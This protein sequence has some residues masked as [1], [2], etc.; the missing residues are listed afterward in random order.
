MSFFARRSQG[1]TLVEVIVVSAVMLL[2]F[3]GLLEGF[4]YSLNLISTSRAKMSALTVAN[5]TVEYIRSL[6]Y[7]AVG[8]V[9]GIPPGMIPQISTTTL[10]SIQ[11]TQKV[12][13][14]YIDDPADGIGVLDSNGITTDYKQAKVTLSWSLKG[15]PHSIFLVTNI[16]PRSIETSV[17]GGTL[18]VNVFDATVTPLPGATV[19][20]VNNTLVPPIDVTRTTDTLGVAL[21]GGAPAGPNY[22]ISVTA[23]GFSTDKTYFA[24]T[25]LP[26]PATQPIAVLEADISTMNFF[27]DALSSVTLETLATKSWSNVEETFSDVTGIASSTAVTVSGGNLA[28]SETAGVYALNG[29]AYLNRVQPPLLAKWDYINIRASLPNQTSMIAKVYA[30]TSTL[31]LIPDTDLPGNSTGF[32]TAA[33]DIRSLSVTSYPNLT[34]GLF[35]KSNIT[36]A[37]PLIADTTVWYVAAKTPLSNVEIGVTGVKS[38]GTRVDGSTVYKTEF[39]TTTNASG[40]RNIDR[41]EYDTYTFE[42][43]LYDISEAC[44]ANPLVVTPNTS[45][46]LELV[47]APNTANSLRVMVE[48]IGGES[49]RNATV[50]LSR[51]GFSQISATG[52]CGQAFFSG[53]SSALDYTLTVSV[54]GYSPQS[55]IDYEVQGDTYKRIT[56]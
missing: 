25:S 30:G 22:E 24:T 8:T 14:E 32:S 44:F 43:T 54:P 21:F 5:D 1:F 56:F 17:G 45:T 29:V 40:R 31:T 36:S 19:R 55:F 20:L 34:V 15:T 10:N 49:I 48:K 18:R 11:F 35:L 39:S 50:T 38:L 9:S 52:G 23:A 7:N 28:L 2:V 53:L 33:I 16:I 26:N 27:I 47:M 6:S 41:L 4:R 37:T 3:G 13:V 12:L 46:T 42:P 51:P